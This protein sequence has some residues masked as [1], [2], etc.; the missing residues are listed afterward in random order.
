MLENRYNFGQIH[1]LTTQK[2]Q[3]SQ[4][5][6]FLNC[7]VRMYTG[8]LMDGRPLYETPG[9]FNVCHFTSHHKGMVT[10]RER[11]R[12]RKKSDHEVRVRVH[13]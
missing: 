9:V 2:L 4:N 6:Q 1:K 5:G 11:D 3:Q 7:D 8:N 12:W 13:L 10:L